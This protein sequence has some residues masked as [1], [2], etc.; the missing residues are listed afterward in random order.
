MARFQNPG[1]FFL[2][3]L[4]A[5]EQ[6]F[7]KAVIENAL[8][9]GYT[10][11]IEP[12][13]GAF[14]MAHL[15]QSV[16]W[17]ADQIDTSDVSMFSSIMGYAITGQD[18]AGL[19]LEADGYEGEDLTDPAV[20]LWTHLV[21][22]TA[23]KAGKT[24]FAELLHDLHKRQEHHVG[25]IR[26]QLQ[27]A[28]ELLSGMRYRPLCMWAHL[29]EVLSDPEALVCINPPTYTA[30]FEKWY[31][32]G[33]RM[34]WKEPPY[35]IFDPETGLVK[36]MCQWAKDA[37]ALVICYEENEPGKTAGA[38]VFA[39]FGVR[40]N[41]NVYLTTNRPDEVEALARGKKIV[42]PGPVA[43]EPLKGPP[44]PAD[45]AITERSRVEVESITRANALYYRSIWTHNFAGK[46]APINLALKVDGY[47]AG[48]FG[49]DPGWLNIGRFGQEERT[50]LLL[51][52]GVTTPHNTLRMGR[53]LS[54]AA[55]T[56]AV[57]KPVLSPLEYEKVESV[58]TAMLTSK[59]ES[60]EERGIMK[61]VRRAK[62][63]KMG[64]RLTY[65]APLNDNSLQGVLTEWLRKEA[66]WRK[67]RAKSM[68]K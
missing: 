46:S 19:R 54:M 5:K 56:R 22:R 35:E 17:P 38:P 33:G 37:K 48:V 24:Y 16:G 3:T 21:L 41:I 44:M 67:A 25:V 12:C 29:T 13:A 64:Y 47:L 10:R 2:G 28:K 66:Q 57:I 20:A 45:H 49:Y 61:L 39:R 9:Q 32:T 40:Q 23:T 30:G 43:M 55:L 11:F 58:V 52:Y 63:S 34:R 36:L 1:S 62:D 18:L 53:L 65:E 27:R 8:R 4:V 7:L 26:K 42:R 60:K 15:A 68:K 31:D 51:T 14:A 6:A 59:P 50:A